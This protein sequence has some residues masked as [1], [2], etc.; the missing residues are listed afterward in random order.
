MTLNLYVNMASFNS[1]PNEIQNK[2]I[3]FHINKKYH[4]TWFMYNQIIKACSLLTDKYDNF[5][6]DQAFYF[7]L[8]RGVKVNI[9]FHDKINKHYICDNKS[10]TD[11]LYKFI[12]SK[13]SS[14]HL[15]NYYINLYDFDRDIF[16]SYHCLDYNN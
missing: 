10:L 12:Y 13:S 11:F 14:Y 15:R 16:E 5:T 3:E 9:I 7:L 1:L 8:N 4:K 2:I 6:M